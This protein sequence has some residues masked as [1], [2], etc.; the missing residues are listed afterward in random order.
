MPK[1][2]SIAFIPD[3]NRRFAVKNNISMLESYKLGTQK[4]WEVMHW[5]AKYPE[6]KVG[7]FYTL[8]LENL[9]RKKTELKLLYGIFDQELDKALQD[10]YFKAN[11]IKLKFIGKLSLLPNRML[12][13]I[14]EVEQA[15]AENTLRTI[16]LALGYNGQTEIVD[17]AKQIALAHS[18][19]ELDL[20]T[21]TPETFGSYLY[22]DFKDPDLIVRTSGTQRLSAFLTYKSSY[23]EFHFSNKF[24]PEFSEQDL[25]L[26]VQDYYAR[27]RKFGL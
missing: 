3:G 16:H 6:L 11:Q 19:G 15:T 20:D 13:K 24:W 18:K 9:E 21:L 27:Q 22:S 12:K 10:P 8:S 5:M 1:L 7:T 23:S 4:A 17:A 14:Q 2:T 26:A 25:D